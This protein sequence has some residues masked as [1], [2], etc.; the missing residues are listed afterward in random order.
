MNARTAPLGHFRRPIRR[1]S[2]CRP[3]RKTGRPSLEALEPKQLLATLTQTYTDSIA[4]STT[5]YTLPIEVPQFNPALGQLLSVEV[6]N[7][8]TVRN[9]FFFEN[10]SPSP[11]NVTQS[12]TG[13]VS[14]SAPAPQ[15]PNTP[16][17]P[18]VLTFNDSYSTALPAYDGMTDFAG[19]SGY[20]RGPTTLSDTGSMTLTPPNDL[21]PYIGTGLVSQLNATFFESSVTGGTG[22][23][24]SLILTQA[25]ADVTVVYTY[26]P[27]LKLGDY[28][29]YDLDGD[30]KQGTTEPAAPG[31]TV[32]LRDGSGG[33]LGTTTT[34]ANGKYE[35]GQLLPGTFLVEFVAPSG[36]ALTT[37]NAGAN[38]FDAQDSDVD[39]T[40]GLSHLINLTDDDPTIDAGLLVPRAS[41]SGSV[42]VDADDD[43]VFDAGEAPITG[44]TLTL[45]GTD[46]LGNPVPAGT[47]TST[48]GGGF[49]Q[50]ANLLPGTYAVTETQPAGYGDGLD[51]FTN[52]PGAAA[53]GSKTTDVLASIALSPGEHD[54][55]NNF[56]EILGA[57]GDFLWYDLD[58]DGQQDSGE[59]GAAGVGVELLNGSGTVLDATTTDGNGYYLFD[60]LLAGTYA[61]RFSAPGGYVFTTKDASTAGTTDLN[62]SDVDPANG[63]TPDTALAAGATNL[64]LD[65][66]LLA[67]PPALSSIAGFVYQD[68]DDDGLKEAG[69]SPISGVRVQLFDASNALVATAFTLADGSYK[70]TNLPAGTYSIVETQP[71]AFFDGKDTVGTP[72]GTTTNDRF[73]NV[74]LP[75]GFDGVDNNFGELL[76]S[77]SGTTYRDATGNGLYYDASFNVIEDT[78]FGS[79]TVRLFVD[80]NGNNVLDGPDGAAVRT[81]STDAVTGSYQ[82]NNLAPGTYFA[83]EVTPSG[84]L[85][86]HPALTNTWTVQAVAPTNYP[87][88]DFDYFRVQDCLRSVSGVYYVINGTRTVTNLR[89]NTNQGDLVEVFFTVNGTAP[90]QFSFVS[91]TA[92][93]PT[94][95][96]SEASQQRIFDLE[97]GFF[98]PGNYSM[99]VQIPNSYYQIDF[100]CGAAIDQLGPAGSNIFYTPQ[101]RL[102]GADNDGNRAPLANPARVDGYVY[103]DANANGRKDAGE[104]PIEMVTVT[105]TGTTSS[106]QNVTL[107]RLTQPDGSYVFDNL[108]PGS[109]RVTETQPAGYADGAETIGSRGGTLLGTDAITGISLSA[110]QNGVG[111]NFGELQASS[112]AGFV[113]VDSDNDGN[114]DSGESGISGVTLRLLGTDAFGRAVDRT[115]TTNSNGAYSFGDLVPGTYRIAESQPSA[116]DDGIDSI[117][118]LGGVRIGNDLIEQIAVG[119]S[120]NGVD[121]NFGE[122]NPATGIGS[123]TTATIGYW[124][125]DNGQSLIRY[126]GRTDSGQTLGQW[127]A[128]SFPRLFGS[129]SGYNLAGRSNAQIADYYKNTIF[130]L[131]SPKAEAQVWATAFSLYASTISLGGNEA[132]SYGFRPTNAGLGAATINVGNYGAALGLTNNSVQ[133]V[134]TLLQ[135]ANATASSGRFTANRGDIANLFSSIN[136]AGD[137]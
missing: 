98:A 35:F 127:M 130:N 121:Y 66:G 129:S 27:F 32:N 52:A 16:P 80:R 136:E 21:S 67:I 87:R 62:D 1:P 77:L 34:D 3:S 106:G 9:T 40:T 53:P 54:P 90:V 70:F 19:T 113:Y 44:V 20:T 15:A 132:R 33:F 95:V 79:V 6:T 82:F 55:D 8:A 22:N 125:N 50:F 46:F 123:D 47:T 92:P 126:F 99:T 102:I 109:Y 104:A 48:S 41:L 10:R 71:S 26:Q 76:A 91:Y 135:R 89:G 96:A 83:Q 38:G 58:A 85:R 2:V 100:V 12:R 42:Y 39:P 74:V 4:L 110:G 112:L 65:A 56:G 119:Q 36:L 24:A 17:W 134:L 68:V 111:Y 51:T 86:T 103:Q 120:Q 61:V 118:S 30:G 28:V 18:L 114:K 128:E 37:P 101:G 97:T 78:P 72:G 11:T 94:F 29:W 31:V 115:T 93:S 122:R 108:S 69:E 73:S 23:D 117:G 7:A 88:N 105:L 116:Y 5:N 63:A 75:A 64:T 13:T 25:G 43:G 60:D 49:Y 59:P 84:Y 131:G 14:L 81:V 124:R 133:S 57:L 107:T 137:I 45:T